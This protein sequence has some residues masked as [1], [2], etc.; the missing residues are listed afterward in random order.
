MIDSIISFKPIKMIPVHLEEK[1]KP[2]RR[3]TV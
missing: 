2:L 1:S 3:I